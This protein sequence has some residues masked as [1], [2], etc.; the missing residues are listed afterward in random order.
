MDFEFRIA[1][2]EAEARE[3]RSENRELK[4]RLTALEDRGGRVV[5]PAPPEP[6]TMVTHVAP[7][8]VSADVVPSGASSS[9]GPM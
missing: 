3:L 5:I 8:P 7:P 4:A 2:I 1:K 9:P 6:A